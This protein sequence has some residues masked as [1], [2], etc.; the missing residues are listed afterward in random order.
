MKY[1]ILDIKILSFICTTPASIIIYIF[2]LSQQ[3]GAHSDF[4]CS[5]L[6]PLAYPN[7]SLFPPHLSPSA[8]LPLSLPSAPRSIRLLPSLHR[9]APAIPTHLDGW[10]RGGRPGTPGKEQG[11]PRLASSRCRTRARAPAV[12]ELQ[13][14]PS[15]GGRRAPCAIPLPGGRAPCV[16]SGD[17]SSPSPIP[18]AAELHNAALPRPPIPL[19]R[20]GSGV[21]MMGQRAVVCA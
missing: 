11:P 7:Y 17:T 3:S 14:V 18:V 4:L 1:I 15:L 6:T 16:I 21:W 13:L 12:A 5:F 20:R 9:P 19:L 8:S 2:P 10:S